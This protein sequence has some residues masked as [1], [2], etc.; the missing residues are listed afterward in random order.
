[1]RRREF[2]TGFGAVSAT[3][4]LGTTWEAGSVIHILPTVNHRRILLK[5]SLQSAHKSPPQF[6]VG[7]RMFKGMQTDTGGLSWCFDASGLE[8]DRL[9]AVHLTDASGRGLCAPWNVSASID[10]S[11]ALPTAGIYVRRRPR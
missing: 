8:A 5:V 3:A 9:Y 1:M 6:H 11:E 4:A 7:A 2:L 10:E